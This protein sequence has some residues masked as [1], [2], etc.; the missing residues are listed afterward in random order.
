M[1]IILIILLAAS[2]LLGEALPTGIIFDS[3]KNGT[4]GLFAF[5]KKGELH[6]ILDTKAHEMYPFAAPDGSFIVYSVPDKPIRDSRADIW[7]L[8]KDKNPQLLV[9]DGAFP[10]TDGENVYFERNNVAFYS[11]NL[12]T[13]KLKKI[14]PTKKSNF[15]GVLIAKPQ[16]K[17][18][19]LYFTA[20]KPQRWYAWRYNIR[21]NQ[22]ENLGIGCQPFPYGDS[23]VWIEDFKKGRRIVKKGKI[24]H[25]SEL[26]EYFPNIINDELL[27]FSATS[28]SDPNHYTAK[29]EIY[30]KFLNSDRTFQI[31]NFGK[32]SRWP[33]AFD[34]ENWVSKK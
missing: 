25:D 20:A 31:T 30:G 21:T 26:I 19:W 22:K 29:Y 6:T 24:L 33:R 10:T 3:N 27:V 5:D 11:F 7:I 16:L 8:H 14:F 9:R 23:A 34:T 12:K 32:T 1:R 15:K 2:S 28:D 13:Q 17:G 18:D 4:F